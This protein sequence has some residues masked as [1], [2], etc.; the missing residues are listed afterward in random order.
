MKA[1]GDE[2]MTAGDW[3]LP[4]TIPCSRIR[5]AFADLHGGVWGFLVVHVGWL[6]W[7]I[8]LG[9]ITGIWHTI[10]CLCFCGL[11]CAF[12]VSAVSFSMA[13]LRYHLYSYAFGPAEFGKH[14]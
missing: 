13:S 4:H 6:G 7:L 5:F 3:K 2:I 10:F 11:A 9:W 1:L 12:L 8:F 14:C